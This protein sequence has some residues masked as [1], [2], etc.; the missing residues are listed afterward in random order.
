M[1]VVI[2]MIINI[3]IRS[4]MINRG[5]QHVAIDVEYLL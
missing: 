3:F 5:T 1:I 4:A 2:V